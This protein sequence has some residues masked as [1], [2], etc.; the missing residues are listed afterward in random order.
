MRITDNGL[1]FKG[2]TAAAN[3][4]DDYEEGSWNPAFTGSSGSIGSTNVGEWEGYYTRIGRLV[5]VQFKITLSNKGSWS[6][7]VRLTGLPYS[8]QVTLPAAGTCA[9]ANV[10]YSGGSVGSINIY[11]TAGV[12]YFRPR[13]THDNDVQAMVQVSECTNTSQF[14]GQFSYITVAS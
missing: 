3:A 12:T 2:D 7:E 5:T 6:G 8:V 13:Y 14:Q 1:T 9:L 4:L 11:V 10:N